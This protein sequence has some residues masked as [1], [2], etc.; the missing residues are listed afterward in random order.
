[1]SDHDLASAVS[2]PARPGGADVN[3][4]GLGAEDRPP[5]IE[6]AASAGKR[7]IPVWLWLAVALSVGGWLRLQGLD[8]D[9]GLHLHPD[10]RFLTQVETAISFPSSL[11][12][13]FNTRLSPLNPANR[14]HG[15]FVYGTLPLFIARAVGDAV[16][17]VA[18]WNIHFVGRVLSALFDLGTVLLTYRLGLLLGGRRAALGAAWLLVFSAFSI[19]QAHFFTVDSC[20]CF[21]ATAALLRMLVAVRDGGLLRH[22]AFGLLFGLALA[23]RVN[24]VLLSPF[25]GL[26]IFWSWWTG[27]E[28]I[29][30]SIAGALVATAICLTT[31]RVFQPYAFTGPGFFDVRFAPDFL[32]SM[33]T[34]QQYVAGAVDYP[35]SVQW[36]GRTPVLFAGKNLLGWGI[37]P[38]W[39]IA[40]IAGVV[41]LV[42]RRKAAPDTSAESVPLGRIAAIFT[43]VLFLY[44]SSQ[45]GATMRYLLPIVPVLAVAAASWLSSRQGRVLR[46]ALAAVVVLTALWAIAF[47]AIYRRPHSRVEASRW[48]YANVPAGSTIAAEHW[49]DALPFG[50]DGNASARYKIIQLPLYADENVQKRREIIEGLAHA[51]IIAISSNRLYRSIP[52]APWRYPLARRYYELLFSGELGFEFERAFTSYP[53]IGP[54]E[55]PDEDAEEAFSVYDHPQILIFRK[56][57]DFSQAKVEQLLSAVSLTGI[58]R[59]TPREASKLYR[60]TL[61]TEIP[62]P[63][64]RT[65]KTA[66]ASLEASPV[67]ALARWFLVLET[68]AAAIFVLLF[69][70]M[71]AMPDRGYG[72]AKVLAWLVPGYVA[73]LFCSTG[74]LANTV[75]TMHGIAGTTVGAGAWTAWR[76]RQELRAFIRRDAGVAVWVET[77]FLITFAAFLVARVLNPP[78]YSGEKPMDFAILNAVVRSRTMPPADPWFAGERLNYFYFGHALV[79]FFGKLTLVPPSIAFNL[80]IP[81]I[82]ALLATSA[83]LVGERL[84]GRIVSGAIAALAVT[85]FGNLEGPRLLFSNP[86]R[87]VNFD[88]FANLHS[89]VLAQ[90]L[91][92]ALLY[93]GAL[94]LASGTGGG[95]PA[96]FIGVLA[97]LLLG[98]VAITSS[99][100][101]LV[102][103]FLQ[104]GFLT[105]AG[106]HS[107]RRL[108]GLVRAAFIWGLV[109]LGSHLLFLPFWSS[110]RSPPQSWGWETNVAPLVDVIAIFGVSLLVVVPALIVRRFG[111]TVHWWSLAAIIVGA[112]LAA[113]LRSSSAGVFAGLSLLGLTVWSTE[114][115][116]EGRVGA[117]LAAA[118]GAIGLGTESVY[119][120]DRRNTIFEFYP[121]MWLLLAVSCGVL[122]PWAA[123]RMR[124]APR[125]AWLVVVSL[126][127]SLAAFTT[128]S[129]AIGQIRHPRV[130]SETPTLDGM[131]YMDRSRPRERDAFD[132]L[133]GRVDGVPVLLEAQGEPYQDF[134]RV[135]MNTGLPTVLGWEPHPYQQGHARPQIDERRQDV[136]TLYSTEDLPLAERLLRKYHVDLVFIGQLERRT[137]P[138]EGLAKFDR[139]PLVQ[140]VYR[141]GEVTIY[142]VPGVLETV[143][144][145]I[146][147]VRATAVPVVVPE[148]KLSQPRNLDVAPDGTFVVADFGHNRMQRFAADLK[149]IGGFG[150]EGENPGE[151]KQPCSVAIAS[152]GMI[153]VADTWNHRVQK[154]KA[155]GEFVVEWQHGFFGPRGIALAGDG[156]VYVADTGNNRVVVLG[157]DGRMIREF[158]KTADESSLRGPIGIAMFGDEVYVADVGNRRI[159]VFSLE[160]RL[161]RSWPVEWQPRGMPEPHLAVGSDGVLWVADPAG[162]R[163]LL[164]DRSG[165]SLGTARAESPL[166]I[167]IGVAVVSSSKAV[168]TNV[169]SNS[170]AFVVRD[171]VPTE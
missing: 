110:F 135:S 93:V 163:V 101:F 38:A 164:F 58:V 57:N 155:S 124:R 1:M 134:G 122:L 161:R 86:S 54:L 166:D 7:R 157:P 35:P 80:A 117:L 118:A 74:L 27:R 125:I 147:P 88:Y 63:G 137:Y 87:A 146:E 60:Q 152:D 131:A 95:P 76:Q 52:R 32:S 78:I 143:K 136:R 3:A 49:D 82:G 45:F 149:P 41:W 138:A 140:P 18:Y 145:W 139:L 70:S 168:V 112:A 96:L 111:A 132:W 72:F 148:G 116:R 46:H 144:T 23:C 61:P 66:V 36:I 40:A 6:R 37:G 34:V 105:T 11:G 119:V 171:G 121:E 44:H 150:S 158:G 31:F 13:Y 8:W 133:N 162:N 48:I 2:H 24:L 102:A 170:L 113:Y 68:L 154:F 92:M 107:G 127:G 114:P 20:A 10:E 55:I 89:N 39:G 26:A 159:V 83:F 90:P 151:F 91:E 77:V 100:S 104:L 115:E 142:A 14:G 4:S 75:S 43:V 97:S 106:Y 109:L 33:K 17:L 81:T 29:G 15:F 51:D 120:W 128:V 12:D 21:F 5:Q 42:I 153:Y 28:G 65:A 30:R 85:F 165:K 59:T 69:R 50:V 94:W 108:A 160:G 64:E 126:A 98:A 99:W 129:G 62:L 167:P 123:R 53:R 84:G 79:G 25:Y 47:T 130:E 141:N 9:Q 103:A 19:Q 16:N 67:A 73:W 71:A 22:T 56:S 169:G 156:R